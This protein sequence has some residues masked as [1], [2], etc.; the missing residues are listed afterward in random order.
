VGIYRTEDGGANWE[1]Y[2]SG[3]PT[4]RVNDI[5][6]PPDGG[7]MRIATYGRGIWELPQLE[8][9][10][11]TLTDGGGKS[12]DRDRVLDNGERGELFITLKNQ[13]SRTVSGIKL[14]LS[15]SNPNVTFPYGNVLRFPPVDGRRTR[16]DSIRVALNGAVGL[17]STDFSIEIEAREL[18]LPDGLKVV[19]T[20][21]L[22]YDEKPAASTTESVEADDNG[23]TITGDPATSPNVASW[24]RRAL[25]PIQHVFWGPDN[26]GQ[27][28]GEKADLP[29]EQALVSP[30]LR[31]GA[32]PLVLSFQ[33]R[34]A[35][36]TGN[37][38]GGVIEISTDGGTSWT[39]VGGSLYNGAISAASDAPLGPARPAF[40]NR[41]TGWPN[42]SN[43]SL[44]LGTAYANQDV[45]LRFR[46][47]ADS[48][49]GAPGW[50]IDN[51]NVS[52]VTGTP[53]AALVPETGV[54]N[55]HH[56]RGSR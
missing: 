25:S 23:W 15:S 16:T 3:L 41:M 31:V 27:T 28:D 13:G 6:M 21:G 50:E 10:R 4:V 48:S 26:N 8:L 17:E 35:F 18:G 11:T 7:F 52:G 46:I 37:W 56:H 20:H 47:G 54:C 51:I 2:G 33:H 49:T 38:D 53:F 39:D 44:D 32:G 40:V 55:P 36:E 22:N 19:A 1:P 9:V 24:Q 5:Y 30:T 43:V 29:D 45:K 42:F 14:T 12:C 34:F